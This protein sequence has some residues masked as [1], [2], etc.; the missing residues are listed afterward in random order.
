MIELIG[1]TSLG[2]FVGLLFGL[3]IAHSKPTVKVVLTLLGAALGGAPVAFLA[4]TTSKWLYPVGLIVGLLLGRFFARWV[5]VSSVKL[6]Q[7]GELPIT[8]MQ[9]YEVFYAKPFASAPSLAVPD[10]D[11]TNFVITAQTAKGFK[12]NVSSYTLGVKLHWV[13]VGL[14]ATRND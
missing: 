12:V 13:A 11:G 8:G 2:L 4:N 1:V 14:R 3:G 5:D 10:I 9:E 6:K 7:E